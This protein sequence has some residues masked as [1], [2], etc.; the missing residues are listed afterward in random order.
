MTDQGVAESSSWWLVGTRCLLDARLV[1][2]E[3][4]ARR[5]GS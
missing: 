4:S 3:T 2:H 5:N 1:F